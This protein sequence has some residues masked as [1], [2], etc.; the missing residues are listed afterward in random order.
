MSSSE[1]SNDTTV[2]SRPKNKRRWIFRYLSI[3]TLACIG[4]LIYI[5]FFGENTVQQRLQYQQEIDSL[6]LLLKQHQDSLEFYRD[7][8]RRLSTDPELM[9]RVVREQYNM[10]RPHEDVYIIEYDNTSK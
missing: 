8:N 6:T 9:E 5:A 3:P 1:Q 7:L 2:T 10:N 4:L